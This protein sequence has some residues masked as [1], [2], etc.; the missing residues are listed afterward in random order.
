MASTLANALRVITLACSFDLIVLDLMLPYVPGGQA[1]SR[2]GLELLRQLR[3]EEGPNKSTMVVGISAFPD[4][5]AAFRAS[6]DEL[7]ILITQFDDEGSWN[8]RFS[9]SSKTSTHGWTYRPNLI[10]WLCARLKKSELGLRTAPLKGYPR[11]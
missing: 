9:V 1:D 10:L 4:E 2:A 5:I 8:R 7:G 6:F 3:S 11:R